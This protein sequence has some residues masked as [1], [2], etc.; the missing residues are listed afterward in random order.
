MKIFIFLITVIC[1]MSATSCNDDNIQDGQ[2]GCQYDGCDLRRQ[3]I[4]I[5]TNASG[6]ISVLA[7]YPDI[8]AIV[9]EEGI[10]GED[11]PSFDGPDIVVICSLPDSMKVIGLQVIFSGELKDT[12]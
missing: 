8:W 1:F 2:G 5:A 9:S 10:I 12:C 7:K 11:D 6:R 4:K 3:T